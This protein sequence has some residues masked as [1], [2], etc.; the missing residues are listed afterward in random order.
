MAALTALYMASVGY[1]SLTKTEGMA[2]GFDVSS[3][4]AG[5][6]R[7]GILWL[8]AIE[9]TAQYADSHRSRYCMKASIHEHLVNTAQRPESFSYLA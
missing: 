1:I 3:Q 6:G 7:T 8:P 2:A 5:F 9:D 4:F